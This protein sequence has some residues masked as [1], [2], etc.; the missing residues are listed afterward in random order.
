MVKVDS[1]DIDC[2]FP[3]E[4]LYQHLYLAT[5]HNYVNA[6][7][8]I[9]RFQG[10]HHAIKRVAFPFQALGL[11]YGFHTTHN[12][13]GCLVLTCLSD[14]SKTGTKHVSISMFSAW[15]ILNFIIVSTKGKCPA[16]HSCICH[17]RNPFFLS[18]QI[19]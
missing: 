13:L 6:K 12:S 8:F 5:K 11:L 17:G 3:L 15:Y 9:L 2:I 10:D 7:G 4:L 16:L 19:L 18:Q 14:R 1:A